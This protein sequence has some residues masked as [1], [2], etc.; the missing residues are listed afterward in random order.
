[1]TTTR[2]KIERPSSASDE[3]NLG[4][5]GIGRLRS[6]PTIPPILGQILEG[7]GPTPMPL[8]ADQ[9]LAA[10]HA[11]ILPEKAPIELID[12]IL[13]YKDRR[14]AGGDL[15]TEGDRH[16]LIKNLLRDV[17]DPLV[18]RLGFHTVT[19]PPLLLTDLS[20]PEPDVAVFRGGLLDYRGRLPQPSDAAIVIEVSWS[21]LSHDRQVK[22]QRYA[23][24]G[25]P[26]YWIVN[27]ES[28]SV[29]VYSRPNER[30]SRYSD[31]KTFDRTATISLP[32]FDAG[33]VEVP[34]ADFLPE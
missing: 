27:L 24:A 26:T 8:T 21:S 22:L 13:I 23:A 30:D 17:I 19:E 2:E 12:G 10:V 31:L 20:V 28:M 4:N 15:M 7:Y 1:M 14:D 9:Y 34:V 6:S 33:T 32:L 3:Q 29:E 11:G 5:R 25:V 16:Y 18:R